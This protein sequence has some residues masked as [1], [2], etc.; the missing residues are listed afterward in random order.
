[1]EETKPRRGVLYWIIGLVVALILWVAVMGIL[2]ASSGKDVIG[3][4]VF[5]IFEGNFSV[6]ECLTGLGASWILWE[7]AKWG[8]YLILAALL[9]TIVIGIWSATQSQ[10]QNRRGP[11]SVRPTDTSSRS[12]TSTRNDDLDKYYRKKD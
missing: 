9:I 12:S 4:C 5:G 8:T 7:I 6:R 2:L 1:M 3:E 10:R 11:R